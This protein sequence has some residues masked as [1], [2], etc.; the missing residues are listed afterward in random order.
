MRFISLLILITLALHVNGQDFCKRIKKEVSED[1]KTF[2]YNSPFDPNDKPT[3]R[4]M[5]NYHLDPEYAYDNFFVIFRMEGPLEDIYIKTADGGQTEKQEKALMVEFDDHSKIVDDTILINHDVSDD[6]TQAV[7][8]L[9]YPMTPETLKDFSSK[10]IV[11]FSLAGVAQSV[12]ADSAASIQQ[13]IQCI[14][15]VK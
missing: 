2:E 8:Y 12:I 13:Y 11:K 3:L 1:K 6:H 5:R 14:K 10:K 4:V 15:S 9:D 7:R